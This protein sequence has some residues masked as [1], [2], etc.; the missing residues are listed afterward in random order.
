M[1]MKE[2]IQAMSPAAP[3]PPSAPEAAGPSSEMAQ[4]KGMTPEERSAFRAQRYQELRDRAAA[5]GLDLPESP[6][7]EG[8]RRLTQE[9]IADYKA[10]MRKITPEDREAYREEHYQKL[11]ERARAAGLEL[12]DAPPWKGPAGPAGPSHPSTAEIDR[13]HQEMVKLRTEM[14]DEIRNMYD[15][16]G[17]MSPEDRQAILD[18]Y[19]PQI[20]EKW[21]QMAR[22]MDQWQPPPPPRMGYGGEPPYGPGAP[23]AGYGPGPY[24][25]Q[26]GPMPPYPPRDYGYGPGGGGYGPGYGPGGGYGYGR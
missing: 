14:R 24:Q 18:L 19:Q 1:R 23:G 20:D 12:P 22:A 5:L 25:G 16:L 10:R 13:L 6:P 17:A 7:W 3:P 2:Q 11:R 26:G 15:R 4:L 8:H 9:E 21:Q